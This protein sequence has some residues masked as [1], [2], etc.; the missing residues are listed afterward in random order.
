MR[1][2]SAG[3][4]EDDEL[5]ER[6]FDAAGRLGEMA[7][8][9]R[10]LEAGRLA[11]LAQAFKECP[12]MLRTAG[13][14][15]EV[16]SAL[17]ELARQD[18]VDGMKQVLVDYGHAAATTTQEATFLQAL[19]AYGEA[20]PELQARKKERGEQEAAGGKGQERQKAAVGKS[21]LET[22]KGKGESAQSRWYDDV[23]EEGATDDEDTLSSGDDGDGR[24]RGRGASNA[25][26]LARFA[27]GQPDKVRAQ[28][29][30]AASGGGGRP[31]LVSDS[32]ALD[33]VGRPEASESDTA[34]ETLTKA[35][36]NH[37]R[38]KELAK[39][40][41]RLV[42]II[43][44]AAQSKPEKARQISAIHWLFADDPAHR[45]KREAYDEDTKAMQS[46]YVR[47]QLRR[48]Y[49][50]NGSSVADVAFDVVQGQCPASR[51]VNLRTDGSYKFQRGDLNTHGHLTRTRNEKLDGLIGSG[52]A[53]SLFAEIVV[54]TVEEQLK[55][56]LRD[57]KIQSEV[58]Y[59]NG[60]FAVERI[61]GNLRAMK[62]DVGVSSEWIGESDAN[63]LFLEAARFYVELAM[64]GAPDPS[65]PDVLA[66]TPEA[67]K[68][69]I[70]WIKSARTISQSSPP[71]RPS[72]SQKSP[73]AKPPKVTFQK[74][75]GSPPREHAKPQLLQR[76]ALIW[77]AA[78]QEGAVT[79]SKGQLHQL[80]AACF[81]DHAFEDLPS[82]AM[83]S[84]GSKQQIREKLQ[85]W[86]RAARRWKLPIGHAP[87]A[88]PAAFVYQ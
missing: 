69:I 76:R 10:I 79:L 81:G 12:V 35:K 22:T 50:K 63:A 27:L 24:P 58:R 83:L 2:R 3:A 14:Q 73:G 32:G 43:G 25:A 75:S 26:M 7:P 71:A 88:S 52:L 74:G 47:S 49:V 34:S 51:G 19:R 1:T 11:K 30:A 61:L 5:Q 28:Q 77:A 82:V 62:E 53:T 21:S 78:Q 64:T 56:D 54:A 66:L 31:L 42:K 6:F 45:H 84:S 8:G 57:S 23:I 46:V 41:K 16:T 4:K 18:D 85:A 55:A 13:V 70:V 68:A 87:A 33:S 40:I 72:P 39:Y 37:R 15:E 36:E 67:L 29:Q 86:V 59:D 80:Y 60:L 17:F 48:C 65:T 44:S 20:S 9:Q 38:E